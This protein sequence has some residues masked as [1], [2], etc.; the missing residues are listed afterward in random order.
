[1]R[2]SDREESRTTE[3]NRDGLSGGSGL[4]DAAAVVLAGGRGKRAGGAK[5]FLSVEGRYLIEQVL[6][7][8]LSIFIDV[9]ISCREEDS[10]PLGKILETLA[11]ISRVTI[12]PDRVEG[13]GPL[14]GISQGLA[15]SRKEW[16]FVTGCDMPLLQDSVV[17]FMWH[18]REEE[19]DAVIARIGGYIEPLHAFYHKRIQK[20]V[21]EGIARSRKKITSFIPDIS[22]LIIEEEEMSHIPGFRRSFTNINTPEDIRKWLEERPGM[23]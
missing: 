20:T 3:R 23:N 7:R 21:E 2:T 4:I 13:L 16:V 15:S 6:R 10:K 1:M 11:D 8:T 19:K 9:I 12:V 17:R 14:Q 18:R 22:P 5:V